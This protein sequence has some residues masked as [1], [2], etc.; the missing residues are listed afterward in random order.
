VL[1]HKS[2]PGQQRTSRSQPYGIAQPATV[3]KVRTGST[4]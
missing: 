4:A 1:V 3:I 2:T